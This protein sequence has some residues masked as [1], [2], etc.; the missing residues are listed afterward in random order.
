MGSTRGRKRSRP[1]S[2]PFEG[3]EG[4][5]ARICMESLLP[6]LN[7]NCNSVCDSLTPSMT[8]LDEDKQAT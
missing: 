7:E 4:E 1:T 2:A 6:R 5:E 3:L 8:I